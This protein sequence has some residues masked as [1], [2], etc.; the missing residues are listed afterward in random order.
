[1]SSF[2]STSDHLKG[3]PVFDEMNFTRFQSEGCRTSSKKPSV[4]LPTKDHPSEQI[5]TTE[6]TNILLRYLHQQWDKKK[7]LKK[8]ETNDD[9]DNESQNARK[10]TKK[11]DSQTNQ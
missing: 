9:N 10:K 4:Y 1:M 8:R 2:Q 3:L 5:I 7:A 6:K 11:N